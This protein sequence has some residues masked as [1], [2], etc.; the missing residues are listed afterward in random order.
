MYNVQCSAEQQTIAP[1]VHQITFGHRMWHVVFLEDAMPH[2]FEGA[3]LR[4]A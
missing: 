3:R 2:H 1:A 4:K